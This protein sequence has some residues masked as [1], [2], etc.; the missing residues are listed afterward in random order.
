MALP[1]L[2]PTSF[3]H[4]AHKDL[5][6]L[7]PVLVY[8][9]GPERDSICRSWGQ[10]HVETFDGLYYYLSA[11]GSYMLVGHHEPEGQRF[12]IQV[13]LLLSPALLTHAGSTRSWSWGRLGPSF[14]TFPSSWDYAPRSSHILSA[15]AHPLIPGCL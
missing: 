3:Q 7:S 14:F 11:K 5:G 15:P 12:S 8:N 9:A 2:D 10:Y 13:R 4:S 6:S 1:D